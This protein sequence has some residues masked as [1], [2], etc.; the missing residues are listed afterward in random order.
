MLAQL[1]CDPPRSQP[2]QIGPS[3]VTRQPVPP[4]TGH[5][6]VGNVS[7][8]A[9]NDSSSCRGDSDLLLCSA[10]FIHLIGQ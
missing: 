5:G 1:A 4:H 7:P 8:S 2:R 10:M 9:V 6:V 3:L